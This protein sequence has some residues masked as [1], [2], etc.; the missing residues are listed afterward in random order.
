[1]THDT[2]ELIQ[3]ISEGVL[4]AILI[5]GGV[6]IG[7]CG[8]KLHKAILFLFGFLAGV[9]LVYFILHNVDID[10]KSDFLHYSLII[11]F[12]IG[13]CIGCLTLWLYKTAI[14]VCGAICGIIIAQSLWH[15]IIGWFPDIQYPEIYNIII[16]ILFAIILGLIAMKFI[17]VIV[18]PLT[19]FI[20]SY[21]MTSGSAYF[22]QVKYIYLYLFEI[23]AKLR[24]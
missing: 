11:A 15:L 9:F 22:I 13:L 12:V 7:F 4:A 8:N 16:V 14:F 19:A 23:A 24:L 17:D 18:K 5:I 3:D 20:G 10:A 21:M 2:P 1:M 6:F